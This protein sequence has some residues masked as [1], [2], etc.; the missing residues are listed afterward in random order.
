MDQQIANQNFASAESLSSAVVFSPGFPLSQQTSRH[1]TRKSTRKQASTPRLSPSIFRPEFPRPKWPSLRSLRRG[2]KSNPPDAPPR[3]T[4]PHYDE[5]AFSRLGR[6]YL[7]TSSSLDLLMCPQVS[8]PSSVILAIIIGYKTSRKKPK[9]A[10]KPAKKT[11]SPP[12]SI[13]Y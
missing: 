2:P 7:G 10:Q 13:S 4:E 3:E 1:S 9:S 12:Q 11:S 5:R 8:P 6:W